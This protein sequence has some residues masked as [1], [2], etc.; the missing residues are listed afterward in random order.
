MTQST[1]FAVLDVNVFGPQV[2]QNDGEER[3]ITINEDGV[4]LISQARDAATQKC[5][6]EGVRYPRKRLP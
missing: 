6:E 2:V 5:R 1:N 4:V 3:R